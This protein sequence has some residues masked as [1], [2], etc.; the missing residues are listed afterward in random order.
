[1]PILC[2][3]SVWNPEGVTFANESD[4]GEQPSIVLVDNSDSVYVVEQFF[5]RV[6]KWSKGSA[7]PTA[8]FA[9]NISQPVSLF[10]TNQKDVYIYHNASGGQI[11]RWNMN[12]TRN[13]TVMNTTDICYSIFVGK[14]RKLYCSMGDLH[15]VVT[16]PLNKPWNETTVVV[17]SLGGLSGSSAAT[18]SH[19]RGIY[20]DTYLRLFIADSGNNRIQRVSSGANVGVTLIGPGSSSTITLNGPTAVI[21]DYWSYVFIADTGNHRIIGG[22]ASGYRC[23]VGCS[24]SYGSAADQLNGPSGLSFDNDGNLFVADQNNSRI[25]KFIKRKESCG[26]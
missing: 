10:V 2:P 18:L 19:P 25:Q 8:T 4:V 22:G 6:Q 3:S 12:A 21:L 1:M 20:V 13:E 9:D 5:D 17:G 15:Q 11:D 14:D 7:I 24:N 16:I 23:V 26:K